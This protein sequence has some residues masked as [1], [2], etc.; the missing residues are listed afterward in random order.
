M[1]NLDRNLYR[2]A[3]QPGEG[4]AVSQTLNTPPPA[5]A[6]MPYNKE[7][8]GTADLVQPYI[9]GGGFVTDAGAIDTTKYF[10]PG[11]WTPSKTA[12]GVYKITHNIGDSARYQL[13]AMANP[14]DSS[15][16]MV[17]VT[18]QNNNDVTV[19]IFSQAGAP[20]DTPFSFV[21]Y[22]NL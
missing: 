7:T 13:V 12:T 9:A 21:V 14:T 17:T 1:M 4:T 18:G 20:I 11:S 6:W 3:D 15:G 16:R 22:Q 19:R 5:P 10:L 2:N 8:Y